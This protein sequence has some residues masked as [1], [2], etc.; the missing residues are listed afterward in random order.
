MKTFKP[1]VITLVTTM[2]T[3]TK[4]YGQ[5]YEAQIRGLNGVLDE[6]YAE[7]LPL[8]EKLIS[9]GR[10]IAAFAAI[11]YIGHR[12]WRHLAS[13]EPVDFYPLLRPFVLGFAIL[14]FPSVISLINGVL[15]PAVRGTSGMV[16]DSDAAITLLLKKKE[17]AIKSSQFWE[18]Y[19]GDDSKGNREKWLKYMY[20]DSYSEGF[21]DGIANDIKFYMAK[22]SYN[23]RNSI[24]AALSE[25]LRVVFEAAALC[26]NTIRTFHLIVLAIIGPLAFGISVFDGFQHTLTTWIAR[27]INIYL[28]LPVANI[29]GAIIGKIQEKM[30]AM[31]IRQIEGSGDTFF[32]AHDM[33]YLIF[34]IIGIVGYF[35]VPSVAGYIIHAG[36]PNGLLHKTTSIFGSTVSSVGR[37]ATPSYPVFGRRASNSS[38]S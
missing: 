23:F 12:I 31:D 37:M 17:D 22:Q 8:C 10:G 11:F 24:K 36:G 5:G 4:G 14:I 15:S 29:F 7:M 16:K 26:I 28:W 35:A 18:M 20:G 21:T 32:N 9:V 30:I 6:L 19:V 3:V 34:L 38:K 33:A 2:L 27:Y 13:A 25:I 1:A